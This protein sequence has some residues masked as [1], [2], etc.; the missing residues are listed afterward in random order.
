MDK[1]I[2]S[3]KYIESAVTN[4]AIKNGYFERKIK[5][6]SKKGFPDRLFISPSGIA[7]FIEFKATKGKITELQQLTINTLKDYKQLVFIVNSI[8]QGKEILNAYL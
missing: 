2:V 8:E 7:I 5:E 1:N 3:E 6:T 4:Y